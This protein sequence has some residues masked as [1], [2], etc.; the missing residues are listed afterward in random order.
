M[1]TV[2]I[3]LLMLNKSR[4]I[5]TTNS[6][7]ISPVIGVLLMVSVTVILAVIV[8]VFVLDLGN[9]Q[10]APSTAGV[11][12]SETADGVEV[13]LVVS[14]TAEEIEIVSNGNV[15]ATWDGNDVGSRVTVTGVGPTDSLVIRGTN[16][17]SA[18]VIKSYVVQ[19]PHSPSLT[20]QLVAGGGGGGG[21]GAGGGGAVSPCGTAPTGAL[22]VDSA[23]GTDDGASP[24]QTVSAAVAGASSG[25]TIWVADGTYTLEVLV[26]K[27]LTITTDCA[28]GVGSGASS[29]Y[30]F[31][32]APGA[33]LTVDGFE[34]R[35]YGTVGGM[36]WNDSAILLSSSDGASLTARNLQVENS[37]AAVN[38]RS[39]SGLGTVLLDNVSALNTYS[40]VYVGSSD[41][42]GVTIRDSL[43]SGAH[44]GIDYSYNSVGWTGTPLTIERT[45]I[46]NSSQD[47]IYHT[48]VGSQVRII[49]S[50]V[51]NNGGDG[52]HHAIPNLFTLQVDN[53]VFENNGDTGLTTEYVN[54]DT[55]YIRNSEFNSQELRLYY[56]FDASYNDATFD[57][58]QNWW[59][60]ASG[61][62]SGQ[63]T[64]DAGSVDTD[65]YCTVFDCTTTS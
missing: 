35:D 55:S 40:G 34:L 45:T 57:A 60:Q 7:G 47:G 61:P 4:K 5:T 51:I 58:E 21:G 63:I 27:D 44:T 30:A 31:Y 20:P 50:Q 16:G 9:S 39:S 41:G 22:V 17:G 18:T 36:G 25:D 64:T 62:A 32:V 49:D 52:F 42:T 24:Y 59:G 53:T 12:F 14:G 43:I 38:I 28:V 15:L 26:D 13:M 6:E 56:V 19:R 46:E 8:A 48:T 33:D 2:N 1:W 29:Q 65:P 3:Y 10:S 37:A 11:E 23:S 54:A